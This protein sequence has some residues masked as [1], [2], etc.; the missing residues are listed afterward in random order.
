MWTFVL[1]YYRIA[2]GFEVFIAY[3]ERR[4]ASSSKEERI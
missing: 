3:D 1:V 2:Q 4:S